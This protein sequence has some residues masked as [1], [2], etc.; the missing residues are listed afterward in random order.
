MDRPGLVAARAVAST[1]ESVSYDP[2]QPR[3]AEE[4]RSVEPEY[5]YSPVKR[6]T[7]FG[8]VLAAWRRSPPSSS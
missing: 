4:P 1:L 7:T 2:Y 8:D 6:P 3:E 5:Q